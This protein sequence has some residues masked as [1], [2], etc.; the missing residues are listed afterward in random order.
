VSSVWFQDGEIGRAHRATIEFGQGSLGGLR[1][2]L[3][4]APLYS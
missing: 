2:T 1:V 4:F 3:R